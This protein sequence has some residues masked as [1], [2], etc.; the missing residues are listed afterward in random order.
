MIWQTKRMIRQWL[1]VADQADV[2]ALR[3]SVRELSVASNHNAEFLKS[4]ID[5]LKVRW[6]LLEKLQ[7]KKTERN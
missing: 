5:V 6:S 7:M 2:D 1:G 4:E 3:K